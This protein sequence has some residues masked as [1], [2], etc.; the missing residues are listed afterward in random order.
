MHE[1]IKE[2]TKYP[3]DQCGSNF[4]HMFSLNRHKMSK[5]EGV[6]YPCNQCESNFTQIST[7]KKHKMSIHKG[8]SYSWDQCEYKGSFWVILRPI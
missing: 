4:T 2:A 6:N 7:F 1:G 3:C 5:H 8:I